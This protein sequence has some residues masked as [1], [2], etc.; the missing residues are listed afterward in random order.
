MLVQH[1]QLSAL[2]TEALSC[3][4]SLFWI[5]NATLRRITIL[6]NSQQLMEMLQRGDPIDVQQFWTVRKI[7][8]LKS[9]FEWCNIQKVDR[10]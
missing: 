9:A 5:V 7:R 4:F 3:L 8:R 1:N 10:Q 6:T 2:Q